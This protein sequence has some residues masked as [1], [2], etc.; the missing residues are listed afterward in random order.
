MGKEIKV[1][2]Y[3]PQFFQALPHLL[4][5]QL[6]TPLLPVD[7]DYRDPLNQNLPG[8]DQ[9]ELINTPQ[10]G[11]LPGTGGSDDRDDLA[12]IYLQ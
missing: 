4:L 7:G 1:L 2:E 10:K 11:A 3:H 12:S 9:L 5:G 8:V 6:E